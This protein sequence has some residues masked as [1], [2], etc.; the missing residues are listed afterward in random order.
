MSRVLLEDLQASYEAGQ[1]QSV[2]FRLRMFCNDEPPA[3]IDLSIVVDS[4]LRTFHPYANEHQL[5]DTALLILQLER[6]SI[7]DRNELDKISN[8]INASFQNAKRKVPYCLSSTELIHELQQL[9][10][11]GQYLH[12]IRRLHQHSLEKLPLG[13]D[14]SMAIEA[15]IHTFR[16]SS[17]EDDIWHAT[18]LKWQLE[19]QNL[20]NPD[21]SKNIFDVVGDVFTNAKG[22][23]PSF[24]IHALISP[25]DK[26]VPEELIRIYSQTKA[27]EAQFILAEWI[28]AF[29]KDKGWL[30][31]V[32]NLYA[33]RIFSNDS[34][35]AILENNSLNAGVRLELEERDAV[36]SAALDFLEIPG[37]KIDNMNDEEKY[38]VESSNR[39]SAA[40]I[41]VVLNRYPDL[42]KESKVRIQSSGDL[43]VTYHCTDRMYDA[44]EEIPLS[45]YLSGGINRLI[46]AV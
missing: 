38:E 11:D 15:V 20:L 22:K 7:L 39:T 12:I 30:V 1:Y 8:V 28:G 33:Q 2:V 34:I 9:H 26:V 44:F 21:D 32:D 36:I 6:Q 5:R 17:D 16:S 37:H 42:T 18:G 45:R 29:Y 3:A 23:V 31:M 13:I 40:R 41:L 43:I 10:A 24:L 4:I 46:F 35:R 27:R 14:V 19:R 25:H